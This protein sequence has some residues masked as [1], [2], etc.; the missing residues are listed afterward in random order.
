MLIQKEKFKEERKKVVNLSIKVL[1]RTRM[2][3]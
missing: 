2:R 3:R 1:G